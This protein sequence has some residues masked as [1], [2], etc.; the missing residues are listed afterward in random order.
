LLKKENMRITIFLS[1]ILLSACA[2]EIP[3]PAHYVSD[4]FWIHN[5]GADMYVATRGNPTEN[6]IIINVH[7]GPAYGAQYVHLARPL[8]YE[9]LEEKAIVVYYDQRGVG[10]STGNFA[11]SLYSLSQFVED[12]DHVI[13]VIKHKYGNQNSIFL[14][15][16]S[17]GGMLTAA[18][19]TNPIRAKKIVGWIEIAGA[20]DAVLTKT[21]GKQQMIEI[22]NEQI[23]F[24]NS[25]PQWKALKSFADNFEPEAESSD[26]Y[27]QLIT[28]WQKA[29]EAQSL[30]AKDGIIQEKEPTHGLSDKDIRRHSAYDPLGVSWNNRVGPEVKIWSAL[31]D[32]SLTSRLSQ[33]TLPTLFI[34]GKYDLM[35]PQALA[36][37]AFQTIGTLQ[38]H[39]YLRIYD[40]QSHYPMGDPN[41]FLSD[42]LPFLEQYR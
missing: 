7:G 5:K 15:G 19:L 26:T 34:W 11:E 16:R 8:V 10:L 39:K 25:V 37:S 24:G 31:A 12:L 4:H 20:H 27:Q 21:A 40:E 3:V 6:T 1:F 23:A 28:Y 14:M 18:Y 29:T 9:K 36:H 17:W 22:A 41:R 35:V 13:E 30:L 32:Y 42:V 38:Q 2:K 33:V